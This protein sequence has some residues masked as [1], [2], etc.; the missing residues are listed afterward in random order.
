ML[1]SFT[2]LA[3][4]LPSGA[5]TARAQGGQRDTT[6]GF[7]IR[8]AAVLA[9]CGGCHSADSTGRLRR[10]S[11]MRK[12]PE[13]WE[14]SIRRMVSLNGVRVEPAVARAI[15]KYLSN[16]QGLAPA[17]LRPG[18]FEVERRPIEYR[19][20]GDSRTE[21]TCRAC[22]SLGRVITQRRTREEWELLVA[23]HRGYYPL[24]DFQSFRRGAPPPPDSAAPHPMDVAIAHLARTF[25]LRTADWAAWSAT[26]RPPP[27]E[28][29]W[30]LSGREPGRGPFYGRMTIAR[31]PNVDDEFTTTASYRFAEGN[32]AVT[33]TG[34]AVVYTG[35]QW[36]GRSSEAAQAVQAG[37]PA[38][39]GGAEDAWREVVFVEPGWQ[40]MSGRWFRGGYDELGMDVTMTRV[41]ASP[42][43]AGMA[44]R[45]LRSGARDQEVT[46]FGANLPAALDAGAVSFG[47]GVRVERVVRATPDEVVLRL[48]VD[49]TAAIG[50]RD[51]YVAGAALRGAAVVY[52]RISRIKVTPNA[53]MAR[54]G[55]VAFP[56]QFQQF[57]AVAYHN[58][59]DGRP[60]TDDD[61]EIGPVPVSWSLEEYGVTFDDD[62]I[63]FVGA[64]DQ[65]GLFTPA[66]DGP[67]PKRSGNR[68]NIG[69]VW[70]VA[71]YAPGGR[72]ARPLK[73]RAHLLV[74]V[75]LY[76]RW[77]PWRVEQ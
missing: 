35:Y 13:G 45:A 60:D 6:S 12:T 23:T 50:A 27:L 61:V 10:L 72:D 29:T 8:D 39:N 59:V 70:V 76:L 71:T 11:Y 34:R 21:T 5:S 44:P 54:V 17:E 66:A 65:R 32:A 63:R 25:P 38:Q 9:S 67:N 36:R 77:E 30:L 47:P 40:E 14:A 7:I 22:H 73:A 4:A 31:V 42:V 57:D 2:V 1:I 33:R 20:T 68:N 43:V 53:G 41:G 51:L 37:R 18:R 55:G 64:I 62:D 3:A 16:Q 58:G 19:Y 75:P 56:K 52:D 46:L 48:G 49:S 28:G 74:T 15:V 26:M 24:V 69:D